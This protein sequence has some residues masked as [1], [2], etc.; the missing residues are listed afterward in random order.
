MKAMKILMGVAVALILV[1]VVVFAIFVANINDL[2]KYGVEEAGS[3]VTQT[4][5]TLSGVDIQLKEARGELSGL[6]IA[7]PKGYSKAD[8]FE[9]DKVVFDIDPSSVTKKGG[10]IVIDEVTISGIKILAEQTGVTDSNL[11]TLLNNIKASTGGGATSSTESASEPA[12][13]SAPVLLAV[14]KL[15]FSDNSLAL[16][17]PTLGDVDV[18]IPSFTLANLGSEE[19]GLTPSELAEAALKPL[20]DRA[21]S[22]VKKK[23]AERA[24]QEVKDKLLDKLDDEQKDRLKGL[25][26][27]L[28]KD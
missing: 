28:K 25:E 20:V 7:N 24:E 16:R 11:Q 12:E 15:V 26:S 14:K 1:I 4:S 2:V 22:A 23:A 13:E 18:E 19:K 21:L 8:I 9:L 10:V 3:K 27:L 5:V 17:S 6:S